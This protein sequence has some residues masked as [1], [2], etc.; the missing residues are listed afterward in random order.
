MYPRV[1]LSPVLHSLPLTLPLWKTV[2]QFGPSRRSLG[3]VGKVGAWYFWYIGRVMVQRIDPG[4]RPPTLL[5]P[6]FWRT[7]IRST[8][9]LSGARREP[10]IRG[11][12]LLRLSRSLLL[13]PRQELLEATL[14]APQDTPPHAPR[15]PRPRAS[16]AGGNHQST[17][18]VLTRSSSIK[19]HSTDYSTPEQSPD[20]YIRVSAVSRAPHLPIFPLDSD[21]LPRPPQWMERVDD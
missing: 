13:P 4:C 7:S 5:T 12:A 6:P 16:T 9:E 21:C 1:S 17:H 3:S 15:R 8:L 11:G 10:R 2:T 19:A 20:S 14:Q 18:L